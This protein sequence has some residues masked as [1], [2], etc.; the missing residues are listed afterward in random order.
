MFL[1]EKLSAASRKNVITFIGLLLS[2]LPVFFQDP[3][4][5]NTVCGVGQDLYYSLYRLSSAIRT[6]RS[7]VQSFQQLR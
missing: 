4:V 5:W 6:R 3:F 1:C 2:D 7:Y